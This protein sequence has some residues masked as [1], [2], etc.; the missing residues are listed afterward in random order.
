[1][2]L[3]SS[4]Q[5]FESL[6]AM[7]DD[8]A[9]ELEIHRILRSMEQR[10]ELMERWRRYHMIGAVMRGEYLATASETEKLAAS[11][12]GSITG[13]TEETT[14]VETRK[15]PSY[16]ATKISGFKDLVSKSAIAASFAATLVMGF[17]YLG[18]SKENGVA[19][20]IA[21]QPNTPAA[22]EPVA[23]V[24]QAPIGFELPL[25]EARTVGLT[26]GSFQSQANEVRV[27]MP[28]YVDDITDYAT[29]EM[30]NRLLIQHAERASVHGSLGIM[31]F[32][33]VHKM[34]V[35][36]QPR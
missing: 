35:D 23:V 12:S 32:A 21:G 10:P 13:L 36:H 16:S 29:Q 9:S 30:L 31:P 15:D 14:S 26:T 1:M 34:Q 8:E 2:T 22:A 19:P 4:D 24:A 6:S 3:N 5:L 27:P 28:A 17:H 7:V 11:V 20:Q 25:P 33:R 18:S